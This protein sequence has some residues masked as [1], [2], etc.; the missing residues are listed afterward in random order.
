MIHVRRPL[1]SQSL[2]HFEWKVSYIHAVAAVKRAVVEAVADRAT[3]NQAAKRA[4]CTPPAA[5]RRKAFW[6]VTACGLTP[7]ITPGHLELTRLDA[8]EV[9]LW[10]KAVSGDVKAV[11]AVLR[12]IEQRSRLLGLDKP[13]ALTGGFRK[14][15][16][17]RVLG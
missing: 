12:I 14:C 8:P 3:T 15:G 11:N 2:R 1:C 6:K 4:S 9:G 13:A 7:S 16:R 10:D 17:S 5:G